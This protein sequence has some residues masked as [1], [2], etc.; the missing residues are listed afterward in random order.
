MSFAM[1]FPG[2]GSQS[3]GMM[4]DWL[5]SNGEEANIF[6]QHFIEASDVLGFDLSELVINGPIEKLNQTENTQ[7]A[8]L[9][10]S[11]ALWELWKSRSDKTPSWMAGHSLGE[12]SALVCAGAMNFADTVKLVQSRGQYMQQ[13]VTAG[14]GAMAAI[15]GLDDAVVEQ[16]CEEVSHASKHLV[17]AVNYNS[18]GQVVIAGTKEGVERA[19]QKLSDAGAKRTLLLPVSVPSHCEL[20]LP[21]AE[22]LAHD[23]RQ[24]KLEIPKIP[25][26]HNVNVQ[27]SENTEQLQQALIDQLTCPV[28]WVE[29][30]QMMSKSGVTHV[31]ECGPGKVLAG[32]CKRIDRQLNVS[33]MENS[34]AL[35]K[36]EQLISQL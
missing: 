16:H 32:L 34:L 29:T 10:S 30:I 13:A 9:V 20:M 12:Y 22:K 8:L 6:K 24:L 36:A 31:A 27:K 26:I 23:I 5:T 17:K 21:A 3:L 35:S 14:S 18:P 11:V 1:I 2:Q 28:R 19:M 15:L 33:V 25:V 7:P 4:A